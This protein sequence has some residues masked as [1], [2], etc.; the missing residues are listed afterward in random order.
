MKVAL[1][2]GGSSAVGAAIGKRLEESGYA[3]VLLSRSQ[4]DFSKPDEIKKAIADQHKKY[5]KIDVGIHVAWPALTRK[6]LL[7]TTE[8]E[9]FLQMKTGVLG[10]FVFLRELGNI[11]QAQK[12]GVLIGIT[13]A[14]LEA[15]GPVGSMGAYVPAKYALHGTLRILR[16]ELSASGV[17]V[18]A[19]APGLMSVGMNKDLP[20]RLF[21]L[22]EEKNGP[23]P[24]PSS[25]ADV[26]MR[27]ASTPESV[28]SISVL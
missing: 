4:C 17:R 1:I 9:F 19:I 13:T 3:V 6:K 8:E 14:A 20:A 7:D 28:F 25:V 26:V 22:L 15:N 2:S 21:Q 12:S 23:L 5:K 27:L 16:D 10:S 18:H 11:M 24:T